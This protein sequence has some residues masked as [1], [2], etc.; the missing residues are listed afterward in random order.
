MRHNVW[1][2]W[3]FFKNS[4]RGGDKA[5]F[6]IHFNDFY[7][8]ISNVMRH[9]VWSNW[10]SM[11]LKKADNDKKRWISKVTRHDVWSRC[12]WSQ[13]TGNTV[14]GQRMLPFEVKTAPRDAL[15]PTRVCHLPPAALCCVTIWLVNTVTSRLLL[16]AGRDLI[17]NKYP[18]PILDHHISHVLLFYS[19]LV[20]LVNFW[21][22]FKM[23]RI[24]MVRCITCKATIRPKQ[25]KLKCR[26]CESSEHRICNFGKFDNLS[27]N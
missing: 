18:S 26:R 4:R 14:S 3:P 8:M 25:E 13:P 27:F 5:G 24:K 22:N 19:L 9:N 12:N 16:T 1:S 2:N 21:I 20:F 17:C 11:F 23:V 10:P 7:R 6:V 15:P